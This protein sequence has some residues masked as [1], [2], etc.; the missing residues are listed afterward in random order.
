MEAG[1]VRLV[2]RRLAYADWDSEDAYD[3]MGSQCCLE[4]GLGRVPVPEHLECSEVKG[5][6]MYQR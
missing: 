6:L 4:Q 1:D 5:K 2:G 3:A